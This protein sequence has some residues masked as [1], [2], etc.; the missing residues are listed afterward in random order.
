M[1]QEPT[2]QKVKFE[3]V[4]YILFRRKWMILACFLAGVVGAAA[5]WKSMDPIYTSEARLLVRYIVESAAM[6][7]PG[8]DETVRQ[9]DARGDTILKT[10]TEILSSADLAREVAEKVGPETI[11]GDASGP[12]SLAAA[13]GVVQGQLRLG[14]HANVIHV[15]FSHKDPSVC[16]PVLTQLIDSY[17]KLHSRLHLTGAEYDTI[18][19]ETAHQKLRLDETER[20][21]SDLRAEMG[22]LSLEDAKRTVAL[23]IESLRKAIL[24]AE[25]DLAAQQAMAPTTA[26]AIGDAVEAD[27]EPS[28]PGAANTPRPMPSVSETLAYQ[29]STERLRELVEEEQDY[30]DRY[31]P[32]NP[33]V[34]AVR[35]QISELEQSVETMLAEHP[36]LAFTVS[37][38]TASPQPGGGAVETSPALKARLSVLRRQLDAA[39]EESLKLSELEREISDL[40]LS[41]EIQTENHRHL[42]TTLE[43]AR[44]DS[45]LHSANRSSINILQEPADPELDADRA[46][47]L[48]AMIFVGLTGIG[49]ALAFLLETVLD[50]R[51]KRA[52]QLEERTKL[53]VYVDIPALASKCR[54]V[55]NN[56]GA[57]RGTGSSSL[58]PSNGKTV[59]PA[60]SPL[61]N[62]TARAYYEALR[63]R[64]IVY[65]ERINL[66]RKPKLVGVAACHARAGVS[67]V[68]HG[69][70]AT[71]SE[72]GGGKVLLVDLNR[73]ANSMHTFEEG[74]PAVPLPELLNQQSEPHSTPGSGDALVRASL[75]ASEEGYHPTR[76]REFDALIPRLK[77][78]DFDFIVF[79][80]PPLTPTS[81][82]FR[83]AGFLD[84]ML[85]VAESERTHTESV[86]RAI[87]LLEESNAKIALVM[88]KTRDYLPRWL[89][90]PQ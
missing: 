59:E 60:G 1:D 61:L 52:V 39:R 66:R 75:T 4:L 90:P 88:N 24:D 70:A 62:G 23:E 27:R 67:S 63:D 9:L 50:P 38:Q 7:P 80:M 16:Q 78:S 8:S 21:L 14:S 11:L 79:D 18:A 69:L 37:A 15:R 12:D 87:S 86:S 2:A 65:F 22:G 44:Y 10:E 17:L 73:G 42:A 64:L 41:K 77:A 81:V 53:P 36:H 40:Q 29:A 84:K 57:L 55:Q 47:K 35:R 51:I 85:L 72:T 45:A 89:R 71:L 68:A 33:L 30:L 56:G 46:R 5:V 76:S 13:T 58:V 82:T 26:A 54:R 19:A 34:R 6:L 25:S 43:Q 74:S 20:R 31:T 32:D 48:S 28:G 49:L 83:V 3:D